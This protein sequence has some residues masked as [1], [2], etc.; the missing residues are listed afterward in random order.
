VAA[1][2]SQWAV[3]AKA[4]VTL[5]ML[6]QLVAGIGF[7]G[8]GNAVPTYAKALAVELQAEPGTRFTYGGIPH[9]VFG[10]VFAHKLA[11]RGFTPQTYLHQRILE[12]IGAPVAAWR[13]LKDGTQPLPTGAFVTASSWATFGRFVLERRRRLAPCFSGS[14]AN[15]RYGLSWWQSPLASE[16]DLIY[17]SGAGGQG[18]YLVPSR[19]AVVVKFGNGSSYAHGTF[20]RRLLT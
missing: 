13:S 18:L 2:F 12:P 19:G 4:R 16:P 14:A 5:R 8:L 7:G 10:A 15:P 11:A 1:T 20:L 6:L 17:A 3:G 9:Q